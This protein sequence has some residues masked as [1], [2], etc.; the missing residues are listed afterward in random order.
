MKKQILFTLVTTAFT[1]LTVSSAFAESEVT[2]L[3]RVKTESCATSELAKAITATADNVLYSEKKVT[4]LEDSL[5]ITTSEKEAGTTA[6]ILGSYPRSG[7][8]AHNKTVARAEADAAAGKV[9]VTTP[10]LF[11]VVYAVQDARGA[12]IGNKGRVSISVTCRVEKIG[13]SI[14]HNASLLSF[15]VKAKGA[16]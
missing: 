1:L 5:G 13:N 16:K 2:K 14:A 9:G 6:K 10:A 11:D 8:V 12:Q 4:V 3:Q 15:D 7:V